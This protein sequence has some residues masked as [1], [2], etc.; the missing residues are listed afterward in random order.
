[1]P[2]T[3]I[4]PIESKLSCPSTKFLASFSNTELL[5]LAF[6]VL[7]DILSPVPLR[8]RLQIVHGTSRLGVLAGYLTLVATLYCSSKRRHISVVRC[9]SVSMYC[10]FINM[11]AFHWELFAAGIYLL[12]QLVVR[13]KCMSAKTQQTQSVRDAMYLRGDQ[14]RCRRSAMPAS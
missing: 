13:V 9:S 7:C 8:E 11:R 10:N 4:L 6:R 12:Q 3:N 14:R 1:M 2:A 5:W